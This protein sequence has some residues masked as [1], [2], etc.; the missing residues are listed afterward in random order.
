MNFP[1]RRPGFLETAGFSAKYISVRFAFFPAASEIL[2]FFV[3][4]MLL[5]APVRAKKF[6]WRDVDFCSWIW[7]MLTSRYVL[8]LNEQL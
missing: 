5:Q 3:S 7:T 2:F 6:R 8:A 4:D 1:M